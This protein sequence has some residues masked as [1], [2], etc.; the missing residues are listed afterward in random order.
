MV[1]APAIVEGG[2]YRVFS[3]VFVGIVRCA[4]RRV[5]HA[6]NHQAECEVTNGREQRDQRILPGIEAGGKTWLLKR[7]SLTD[8][9][10][11]KLSG[12]LLTAGASD[13]DSK[14]HET[15]TIA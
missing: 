7:S 4:N 8:A 13:D 6:L 15:A 5:G 14:R 10:Y 12:N 1:P 11:V 9:I 2:K 3:S